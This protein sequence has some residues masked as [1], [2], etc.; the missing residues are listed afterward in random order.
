MT[1]LL[2]HIFK[3]ESMEAKIVIMYIIFDEIV[4]VIFIVLLKIFGIFNHVDVSLF[5]IAPRFE[6]PT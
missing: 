6:N 1:K 3:I 2:N 5:N 4:I